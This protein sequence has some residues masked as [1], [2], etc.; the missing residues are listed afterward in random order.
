MPSLNVASVQSRVPPKEHKVTLIA[1]ADLL[2]RANV[3]RVSEPLRRFGQKPLS[4]GR[5][6]AQ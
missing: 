4:R 6:N 1:V 2:W 5:A 3:E